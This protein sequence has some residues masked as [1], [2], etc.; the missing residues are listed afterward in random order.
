[1]R[2]GQHVTSDTT[3]FRAPIGTTGLINGFSSRLGTKL[4]GLNTE[5]QVYRQT[6]LQGVSPSTASPTTFSPPPPL[7]SPSHLRQAWLVQSLLNRENRSKQSKTNQG[8][9]HSVAF[10]VCSGRPGTINQCVFG[11]PIDLCRSRIIFQR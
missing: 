4:D 11:V 10:C 7:P 5:W 6:K 9:K 1:M 2:R 3:R 8:E